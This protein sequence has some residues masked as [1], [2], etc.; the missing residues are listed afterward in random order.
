MYNKFISNKACFSKKP[1]RVPRLAKLERKFDPLEKNEMKRKFRVHF[2]SALKYLKRTKRWIAYQLSLMR[3]WP[4]PCTNLRSVYT[5]RCDCRIRHLT[6]NRIDPIFCR[7]RHWKS[8]PTLK[9]TV[10][11]NRPLVSGD[12]GLLHV[13]HTYVMPRDLNWLHMYIQLTKL[14]MTSTRLCENL[15]STHPTLVYLRTIHQVPIT[16]FCLSLQLHSKLR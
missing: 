8:H 2:L 14:H 1:C 5:N 12:C 6:K 3:P 7:I 15:S 16:I 4:A 10:R 13:L 9:I 11:V